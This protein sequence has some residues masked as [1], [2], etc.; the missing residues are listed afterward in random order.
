MCLAMHVVFWLTR[1]C[2]AACEAAVQE[3]NDLIK[4][5]FLMRWFSE[6]CRIRHPA[7]F[8]LMFNSPKTF[9]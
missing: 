6:V 9:I 8:E 1:C 7:Q 5:A 3:K 4:V 2:L